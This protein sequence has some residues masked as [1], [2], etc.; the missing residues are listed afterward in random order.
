MVT[1]AVSAAGC[2]KTYVARV[3]EEREVALTDRWNATD[4]RLTAEAMVN[5]MLTFP[6]MEEF[7]RTHQGLRPTIVVHTI[8]NNSHEHVP[9]D[10]FINDLKRE[11]IRSGKAD[12]IVNDGERESARDEI[13]DQKTY[14]S[15]ETRQSLG[16]EQ[17]ANFILSGSIDSI[18]DQVDNK[19]VT[20][21]Q[22]DLKLIE[23]ETMREVWNGQK[24]IQKYFKRRR[25]AF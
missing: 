18:V 22:V 16:K 14:T 5:D 6:W 19:R 11:V 23:L 12:F 15:P 1:V 20:F 17:G 25:L 3:D 13:R 7:Q 10:L 4:S 8:A 24:K 21:F 9:V 2:S